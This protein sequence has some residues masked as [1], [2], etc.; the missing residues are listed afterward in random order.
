[1]AELPLGP[2]AIVPFYQIFFGWEGSPT[3]I[4]Y[5]KRSWHPYFN[6]STEGPSYV[7]IFARRLG[8]CG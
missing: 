2:P 7:L 5:R 8:A 3:K 4:D 1:M 6:L